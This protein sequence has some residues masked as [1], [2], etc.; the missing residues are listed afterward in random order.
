V[1]ITTNSVGDIK[2]G[3]AFS[4]V[5]DAG[6]QGLYAN[7]SDPLSWTLAEPFNTAKMDLEWSNGAFSSGVQGYY[8]DS[9]DFLN[10]GDLDSM[11]TFDVHFTWR[12]PWNADLS[13][14]ASNVLNAGTPDST[15][16]QN[17]PVDPLESI[18]GRIPYVRYKQDL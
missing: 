14:G 7:S 18:Y 13:V 9:V 10:R 15:E 17:Q 12:A 5:L 8:R 1:G 16:V 4:R 2:L 3:L 11:A 6:Y